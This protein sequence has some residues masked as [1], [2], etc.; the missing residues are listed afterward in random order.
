MDA[1][2]AVSLSSSSSPIPVIH[3]AV[4]PHNDAESTLLADQTSHLTLATSTGGSNY[5]VNAASSTIVSQGPAPG[6]SRRR[7]RACSACCRVSDDATS[8]QHA[9]QPALPIEPSFPSTTALYLDA[10]AQ[11]FQPEAHENAREGSRV[12]YAGLAGYERNERKQT[13]DSAIVDSQSKAVFPTRCRCLRTD[14]SEARLT[15]AN[16][17]NEVLL[18]VLSYLDVSDLLATSRVSAVS[19]LLLNQSFAQTLHVIRPIFMIPSLPRRHMRQPELGC[20]A[21]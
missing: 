15:L 10:D 6:A 4:L 20:S 8:M 14:R 19:L 18:H 16:F 12:G 1:S 2:T 5:L 13:L 17:P 11:T 3:G 7:R 9:R 21:F